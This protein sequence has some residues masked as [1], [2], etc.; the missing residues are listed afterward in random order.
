MLIA[1]LVFAVN[2]NN[3]W[4]VLVVQKLKSSL[5]VELAKYLVAACKKKKKSIYLSIHPLY[6]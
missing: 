5:E 4:F 6:L 2:K 3:K 1:N